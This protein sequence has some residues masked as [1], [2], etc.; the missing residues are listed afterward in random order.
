MGILGRGWG[1]RV[2]GGLL[3][4]GLK[5]ERVC[6]VWVWRVLWLLRRRGLVL[7]FAVSEVGVGVLVVAFWSEGC[8]VCRDLS[9]Y[10]VGMDN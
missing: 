10:W 2:V 9:G 4:L 5:G 8:R 7:L 3:V 1:R 6:G